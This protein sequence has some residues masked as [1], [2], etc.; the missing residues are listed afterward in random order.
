MQTLGGLQHNRGFEHSL[1]L[2]E[3][4]ANHFSSAEYIPGWKVTFTE[5]G[6][7]GFKW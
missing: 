4:G 5:D 7:H 2:V 3:D 6:K 1:T